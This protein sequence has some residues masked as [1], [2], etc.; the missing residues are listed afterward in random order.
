MKLTQEL[1]GVTVQNEESST[2]DGYNF[3]KGS[4]TLDSDQA[5]AY[6]RQRDLPGNDLAR[7]TNQ[8][9][10]MEGI[11][12]K[13]MSKST[14]ANPAKFN[15]IVESVAKEVVVD[16]ELTASELRGELLSVRFKPSELRS[17]QLPVA[18]Y[19]A[20]NGPRGTATVDKKKLKTL[21]KALNDDDVE[22]YPNG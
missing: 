1:G 5:L 17:I 22:G 15:R 11:L 10:V 19:S 16:R 14:I 7:T 21:T 3:P 13:T 6:V 8:R 9:L 20:T 12:R 2:S 18:R 4:I